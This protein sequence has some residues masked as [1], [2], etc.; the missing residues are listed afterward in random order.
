MNKVL[1]NINKEDEIR[2]YKKLNMISK[3]KIKKKVKKIRMR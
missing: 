3:L 1:I 2:E